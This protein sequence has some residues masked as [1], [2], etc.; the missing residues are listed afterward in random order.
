MLSAK[1]NVDLSVV[2]HELSTAH[3]SDDREKIEASE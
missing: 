2:G 1:V 3:F